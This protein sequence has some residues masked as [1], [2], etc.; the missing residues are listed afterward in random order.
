MNEIFER[1]K[2]HAYSEANFYL[3]Y[4][5][6]RIIFTENKNTKGCIWTDG[7][8]IYVNKDFANLRLKEQY[9]VVCHEFMH[10]V[11]CHVERGYA[12]KA[13]TGALNLEVWNIAADIIVNEKLDSTGDEYRKVPASY[14][15]REKYGVQGKTTEEIYEELL[16]NGVSERADGDG[17]PDDLEGDN[18]DDE[19]AKQAEEEQETIKRIKEKFGGQ[20]G[21]LQNAKN[22]ETAGAGKEAAVAAG[23]EDNS[24]D[25][26]EGDDEDSEE[27]DSPCGHGYSKTGIFDREIQADRSVKAEKNWFKAIERYLDHDLV[28]QGY[29]IDLDSSFKRPSRRNFDSRIIL[30]NHRVKTMCS[31][32]KLQ[33][34]VD[35][36]SSMGTLP[37][38]IFGR[39][40]SLE[41]YLKKYDCEYYA[42]DTLL[43]AVDPKGYIPCGGGTD[44]SCLLELPKSNLLIIITDCEDDISS[45]EK[46]ARDNRNIF[47]ITNNPGSGIKD[48]NKHKVMVVDK[49]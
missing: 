5:I 25:T 47:I 16:A 6:N 1:L 8:F 37:Q 41:R 10:I 22:N 24:T 29:D 33:I 19:S 43:K 11:Y 3:A 20:E 31:K 4:F 14:C 2:E 38:T 48:T 44:I 17:S 30:K 45:L 36:S 12:Y 46:I 42:F 39:I 28:S 26:D 34:C 9:A 7:S 27:Q 21:E 15:R 35:T 32:K 49:F 18:S 23:E 13:R 40:L